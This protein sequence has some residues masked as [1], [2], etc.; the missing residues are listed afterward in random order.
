MCNKIDCYHIALME[1]TVEAA[2]RKLLTKGSV[3]FL[4]KPAD[5]KKAWHP[6]N[7]VPVNMFHS[8]GP[9]LVAH[10]V[11]IYIYTVPNT[12]KCLSTYLHTYL[13]PYCTVHTFI[14]TFFNSVFHPT[15]NIP[16]PV[17]QVRQGFVNISCL[18]GTVYLQQV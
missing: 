7:I 11:F 8:H 16:P 5:G 1:K 13:H 10:T 9:N 2:G 6:A 17:S 15:K 14:Q 18:F 3:S 12:Q 4:K